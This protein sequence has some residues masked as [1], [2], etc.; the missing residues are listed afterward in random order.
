MT[1]TSLTCV[2]VASVLAGFFLL[3]SIAAASC[4]PHKAMVEVLSAKYSEAP[5]AMGTV[6]DDKLVELFVS[7]KGS[8]TILVTRP[9]GSSCIIA[10]GQD[11]EF[12]PADLRSLEPEA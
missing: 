12:V 5:H 2:R 9:N 1:A 3:P 6:H 10:A 4:G 7:A 11:W 8:W